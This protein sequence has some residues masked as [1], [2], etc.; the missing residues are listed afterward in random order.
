MSSE[1]LVL[2][3]S[4]VHDVDG[5]KGLVLWRS[6][7]S[8]GRRDIYSLP[9]LIEEDSEK[10]RQ[11]YLS[12]INELS[13][14]N[15]GSKGLQARM[16]IRPGF[17]YWWMTLIN[18]RSYAKSPKIYDVLR[19]FAFEDL[20]DKIKPKKVSIV[21]ENVDL[22]ETIKRFCESA[23]YTYVSSSKSKT[24]K[25]LLILSSFTYGLE[26]FK[27]VCRIIKQFSKYQMIKEKSEC[28]ARDSS[29]VLLLDYFFQLDETCFESGIFK[30][31]YWTGLVGKIRASSFSTL[32]LH[33]Y[34]KYQKITSPAAA[35]KLIKQFNKN[36]ELDEKHQCLEANLNLAILIKI[37]KDYITLVRIFFNFKDVYKVFRP[38]GSHL[39]LWPFYRDDW[40]NSFL[41]STAV[42]NCFKLNLF[43]TH[44]SQSCPKKLGIYLQ[45][46][47]G[48]EFA[49]VFL[50]KLYGHGKL[51][52]V[53]HTT[54]QF[55]DLRYHHCPKQFHSNL[56]F[57]VPR[58]NFV[59]VN[60]RLAWKTYLTAGYPKSEILPVEAL[61][62]LYINNFK[63]LKTKNLQQGFAKTLR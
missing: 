2:L 8:T 31:N 15:V 14:S 55:W 27:S 34:V 4:E 59:A 63:K 50:W 29:E 61:R 28:C 39:F 51:I 49:F 38:K 9:Y 40:V 18:E 25:P 62:Y 43:E 36:S 58:P 47:Q 60:N 5:V 44:L 35:K 3:D 57:P 45:E 56:E 33:Q 32:W 23:G 12:W 54:I 10:Y 7:N 21:S 48:W 11:R 37:T 26:I 30:S 20:C 24:V 53:P 1:H 52:G 41:G 42:G 13:S 16:Q 22:I 6:F 46:N 17:T 19:L